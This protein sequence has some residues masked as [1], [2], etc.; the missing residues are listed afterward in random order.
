[1]MNNQDD[2]LGLFDEMPDALAGCP[3][4]DAAQTAIA[5]AS[6]AIEPI[7]AS[8]DLLPLAQAYAASMASKAIKAGYEVTHLHVYTDATGQPIYWKT[9]AKHPTF[10]SLS[11]EQ[12][13]A[14]A[15]AAGANGNKWIRAFHHDGANF[16]SKEP[17]FNGAKPLYLLHTLTT[18]TDQPV[19]VV[20]GEQKADYLRSLGL[21]ATTSGGTSS[22]N[23]TD[24]QPL[25]GRGVIVWPDNDDAGQ[26]Y[27]DAL[28][29]LLNAIGCTVQAID[30]SAL[31]LPPKGDVIDWQQQRTADGL[32]STKSD[33]LALPMVAVD[34]VAVV[35]PIAQPSHDSSK[36]SAA[37]AAIEAALSLADTD[38]GELWHAQTI[39]AVQHIYD[40]N[41]AEWARLRVRLKQ[42]KDLKLS[43]YEREIVPVSDVGQEPNTAALLIGLATNLCTFVHDK[44]GEPYALINNDGIRE[45]WHINSKHFSEW[46]SYSYYKSEGTAPNDNAQKSALSTLAG[47]AKFEGDEVS[48]HTRIA[49]HDGAY[50]LDLCNEQWQAV[51]ITAQGWQVIDHPPVIF[52]RGQSMRPLPTP[53]AGTGNLGALWG[54]V[55]IPEN[56]RLIIITWLLECLRPE[57]PFVVLELSGEQGSAKSSTQSVLR[58]LID[59]NKSNLRTIPKQKDDVFISARNSHLVSF[60]NLSHLTP[61]YQDTLCSLATGAGYAKRTL[62]TDVEETT[63]E[64]KKPIILNG[65][66]VVVTAQDL[67]DRAIHLDLQVLETVATESDI[68]ECWKASY[69]ATFTGLLDTFSRALAQLDKVDLSGE[70]L[71]RMADFT[72]L[73][74]AV[75]QINGQPQ[76]AFLHDY[77]ERRKDGVNRT[78]ESSPV[79]MAMV[80]YLEKNP[81]G[82]EGTVKRLLEELENYREDGDAWPKSAKGLGD[83]IERLKPSF[84]QIGIKLHKDL[85][86]SR[87][88]IHCLLK[89]SHPYISVAI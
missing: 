6:A 82:F 39:E 61:E 24:W 37:M 30:T 19:Y 16:V 71:P 4:V 2:N 5:I 67:L 29:P 81:N 44:D 66:P 54:A 72:L 8:L 36:T 83:A 25:A 20:E 18:E 88:G 69:G 32:T 34:A 13:K 57:T 75:Y 85:K 52:V 58:D 1:M 79:A 42:C 51:R 60:E 62:Y 49:K 87:D 43:D 31:N 59:P 7:P 27:L 76:K 28:A 48:T 3:T 41:K 12:K 68:K 17:V 46:L 70:K 15:T 55:N 84:R 26:K 40:T 63:V 23:T 74:E 9:R 73:G 21:I 47:K 77:R 38:I 45:C 50:W 14:I 33:V 11:P 65:I 10:D 53:T 35:A 78:L 56:D 89:K 64:L 22:A 86:R 80:A